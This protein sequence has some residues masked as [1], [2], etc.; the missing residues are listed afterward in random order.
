MITVHLG[1]PGPSERG[2]KSKGRPEA[3]LAT[4]AMGPLWYYGFPCGFP[5]P[6]GETTNGRI[7]SLSSCSTMWQCQT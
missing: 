1:R 5:C 6:R 2:R 7:I 4:P 3:A